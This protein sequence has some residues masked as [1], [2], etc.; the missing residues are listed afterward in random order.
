MG[1]D[2]GEYIVR[3]QDIVNHSY[4]NSTTILTS[5]SL[6]TIEEKS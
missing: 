1:Y 5:F 4:H 2:Y 3:E 6:D